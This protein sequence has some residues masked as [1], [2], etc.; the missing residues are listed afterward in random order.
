NGQVTVLF[1]YTPKHSPYCGITG[2][3][4]FPSDYSMA[5]DEVGSK[6]IFAVL[7]TKKPIDYDDVKK[8]INQTQGM[9]LTD[10]MGKVFAHK[11][12]Q[13]LKISGSSSLNFTTEVNEQQVVY[14]VIGV[15]K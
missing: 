4:L 5:P 6:D 1:P 15:N 8:Q 14:F 13:S 12:S 3:R 2:T 9:D 7:V 11:T 10:K